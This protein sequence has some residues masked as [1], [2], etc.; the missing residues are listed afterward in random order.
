M[1]KY[2]KADLERRMNG[3]VESGG[4]AVQRSGRSWT[5]R[6]DRPRGV[7]QNSRAQRPQKKI[8]S[9]GILW[10]FASDIHASLLDLTQLKSIKKELLLR[11]C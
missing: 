8:I 1:A 5:L 3:A 10:G 2:D 9:H 7:N 11:Q 6:P 4:S